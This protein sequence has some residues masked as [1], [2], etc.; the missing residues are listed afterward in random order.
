MGTPLRA[1]ALRHAGHDRLRR[2][3]GR[4]VVAVRLRG[5][6]LRHGVVEHGEPH[7]V[8]GRRRRAAERAAGPGLHGAVDPA[9]HSDRHRADA[10]RARHR[11]LRRAWRRPSRPRRHRR[12]RP[13]DAD[14]G[15][16]RG[17]PGRHRCRPHPH[18]H[19]VAVVA[20]PASLAPRVGHRD[21]DVRRPRRRVPGALRDQRRRAGCHRL[22][23]AHRRPDDDVHRELSPGRPARRPGRTQAVRDRDVH[24]VRGLPGGGRAGPRL[25]HAG[26]RLRRGRLA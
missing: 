13:V 9:P 2:V 16:P 23:C 1:P 19:G 18:R 6:A 12:A 11:R 24:R 15:P 10:G 22:R 7:A 8:R 14:R 5:I 25:R 17:H 4:A 26:R 20:G 21:P 3:L